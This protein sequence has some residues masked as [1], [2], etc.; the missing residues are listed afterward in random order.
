MIRNFA[1]KE[2]APLVKEAEENETCPV[3][4]ISKLGK[5]GYLCPAFP[6][7]YGG[8]GSGKIGDCIMFEEIARICSGICSGLMAPS[9]LATTAML[10]R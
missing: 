8:G 1:E 9:G 4:L 6:V 7:E 10:A 2:V 3:E 5:L